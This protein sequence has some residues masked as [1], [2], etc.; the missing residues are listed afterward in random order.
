MIPNDS[1]SHVLYLL[2]WNLKLLMQRVATLDRR[3]IGSMMK[4]IPYVVRV[5][6]VIIGLTAIGCMDHNV[7]TISWMQF[8][9]KWN[10]VIDLVDSCYS[11]L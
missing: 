11:S 6:Q 7:V 1:Q 9:K 3:D 8:G 2:I 5:A 10:A 4:D